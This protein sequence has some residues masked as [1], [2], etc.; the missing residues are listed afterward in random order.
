M[1]ALAKIQPTLSTYIDRLNSDYLETGKFPGIFAN[2]L[3][4]KIRKSPKYWQNIKRRQWVLVFV[5]NFIHQRINSYPSN[6]QN[7]TTLFE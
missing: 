2:F 4:N 6:L 1:E 5:W 7:G 3:K